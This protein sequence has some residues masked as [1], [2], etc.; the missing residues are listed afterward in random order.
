MIEASLSELVFSFGTQVGSTANAARSTSGGGVVT[1]GTDGEAAT[2]CASAICAAGAAAGATVGVAVAVKHAPL[3]HAFLSAA[4]S[5]FRT[6]ARGSRKG[7]LG[8]EAGAGA[9]EVAV[10][11]EGTVEEGVEDKVV[12]EEGM[13]EDR[14]EKEHGVG[15]LSSLISSYDPMAAVLL[16]SEVAAGVEG[17]TDEQKEK[18]ERKEKR[19]QKDKGEQREKRERKKGLDKENGGEE[20]E[21]GMTGE[22]KAGRGMKTG[23]S[24]GK[25]EQSRKH[26]EK[27]ARKSRREE[28]RRL[29]EQTK[30][31]QHWQQQM[32]QDTHAP[33]HSSRDGTPEGRSPPSH[34]YQSVSPFY[35]LVFEAPQKQS[36]RTPES[37]APPS[38]ACHSDAP[39]HT[40][41]LHSPEPQSPI[42]AIPTR[43]VTTSSIPT[44]T[45][46]T[47][48]L[49][50]H[51]YHSVSPPYAPL[52]NA[53]ESIAPFPSSPIAPPTH[54]Y[55]QRSTS[56]E[57]HSYDPLSSHLHQSHLHQSHPHQSHSHQ[58]HLHQSH[59]QQSLL[60]QP[61][62]YQP[63]PAHHLALSDAHTTHS[64]TTLSHAITTPSHEFTS[65]ALTSHT[66]TAPTPSLL[67]LRYVTALEER[68]RL[69]AAKL[70][71]SALSVS[72]HAQH[73]AATDRSNHLMAQKVELSKGEKA[74][75]E[76]EGRERR[77]R[78]ELAGFARACADELV[79]GL[80]VMLVVIGMTGWRFAG[81]RLAAG[82]AACQVRHDPA[83]DASSFLGV[84][85][86]RPDRS[87]V[88]WLR[89]I[90][91][92]LTVAG[93]MLL[94]FLVA[95]ATTYIMLLNNVAAATG[96][97]SAHSRPATTIVLCLGCV[98][99][100]FGF[101]AVR[102][103]G[104][105][106]LVWLLCWEGLCVLHAV[107][108]WRKEQLFRVLYGRRAGEEVEE[109]GRVG[110]GA[111]GEGERRG[112]IGEA[113]TGS[114]L[115]GGA[116]GVGRVAVAGAS[117]T[118]GAA[119]GVATAAAAQ[120]VRRRRGENVPSR[121]QTGPSRDTAGRSREHLENNGDSG[122]RGDSGRGSGKGVGWKG[123]G[124]GKM[125]GGVW[126][127][128][129]EI[130]TAVMDDD[131]DGLV[132]G[133][134]WAANRRGAGG[135]SASR[136]SSSSSVCNPAESELSRLLFHLTLLLL[137]PVA[138]GALPFVTW[139][140]VIRFIGALFS[141]VWMMAAG[142][143]WQWEPQEQE[144][145]W[146]GLN[147]QGY[148][149]NSPLGASAP[150]GVMGAD[151]F[152]AAGAS[153]GAGAGGSMARYWE[154]DL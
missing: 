56:G 65:H 112:G 89:L 17:H 116:T 54:P 14:E 133:R 12:G 59:L 36:S 125:V 79:A 61:H 11:K 127:R 139:A 1:A 97:G 20:E 45:P 150:Q 141:E 136:R 132:M 92:K 21:R 111:E 10:G 99:G 22:C 98:C 126:R 88:T 84:S 77:G 43:S 101:Y 7:E 24:T 35:A 118:G 69:S 52:S 42:P 5:T 140:D 27:S 55:H 121:E 119:A 154:D 107:V 90:G 15:V 81:E 85:F 46:E 95:S 71:Q 38:D 18:G 44:H 50:S 75:R 62:P 147:G 68:N 28:P 144:R 134:W 3:P 117:A 87:L 152:T 73:L 128:M 113:C 91:C 63:M 25:Q 29:Q 78:E 39:P 58:S 106:A 70:S 82:V 9:G 131:V 13:E 110:M 115:E 114:G 64:H 6:C 48:S 122:Y 26:K 23:G 57:P 142:W 60:Y 146:D 135:R 31:Q 120:G 153:A 86:S 16:Q 53:P 72:L 4:L 143:V 138:A 105:D 94:A 30:K 148:G 37:H 49:P 33:A 74:R 41:Q 145:G 66:V 51:P 76:Q 83:L 34:A 108:A 80:L 32:Q 124:I 8:K 149:H 93:Q 100:Y 40:P 129:A 103:A 47:H 137:L 102:L 104:G 109:V 67:A 130:V 19:E 2:L 96:A 151:S 123:H